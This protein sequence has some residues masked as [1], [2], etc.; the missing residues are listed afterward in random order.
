MIIY[1][2]YCLH[3]LITGIEPTKL[4][5]MNR[6]VNQENKDHLDALDGSAIAF[7]AVK[8]GDEQ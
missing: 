1:Y 5:C 3:P 4:Y 7:E 2:C 8:S 6:D